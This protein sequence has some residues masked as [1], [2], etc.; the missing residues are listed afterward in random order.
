MELIESLQFGNILVFSGALVSL[1]VGSITIYE[2]LIKPRHRIT[3]LKTAVSLINDW[4]DYIDCNL[5]KGIDFPVLDNK[6]KKISEY[7]KA[8][9]R[10]YKIS[11]GRRRRY[12]WLKEVG[13]KKTLRGSNELFTMYSRMLAEGENLD[14]YFMKIVGSFYSFHSKYKSPNPAGCNFAEIEMPV[15]F[16]NFLIR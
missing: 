1:I 13:I 5:E 14:F 16:L 12:A 11:L 7:I 3:K 10:N 2:K 15:K 9:L 8:N 4:F 6:E